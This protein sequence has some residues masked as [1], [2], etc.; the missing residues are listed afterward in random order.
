MA[1]PTHPEGKAAP[2]FSLVSILSIIAAVVSFQFGFTLGLV[3]AVVAII[4]GAI[5]AIAAL[6]P[7]TRGGMLSIVAIVAG[8]IGV[9]AAV[10]RL[11]GGNLV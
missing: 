4:L 6:L 11:L 8:A 5:G 2:T 3:L 1:T 10:F 9:I 7:G